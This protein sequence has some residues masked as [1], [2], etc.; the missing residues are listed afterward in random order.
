MPVDPKD[1]ATAAEVA[2]EDAGED[3]DAAADAAMAT[4]EDARWNVGVVEAALE[5]NFLGAF[6]PTPLASDVPEDLEVLV[7]ENQMLYPG[8]DVDRIAVRRYP[9]GSLA[10]HA[11]GYVGRIT[12]EDLE[13][14]AVID[15]RQALR[16]DRRDRP[17]R[18]GGVL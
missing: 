7:A 11:L 2:A 17:H 10:A 14:D 4:A 12:Q 9:H 18:R 15:V 5:N 8:V 6:V 1:A 3:P 13:T 16:R